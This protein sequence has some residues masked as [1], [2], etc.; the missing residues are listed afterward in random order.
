[1]DDWTLLFWLAD[2][3]NVFPSGHKQTLSLLTLV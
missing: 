1:M 2:C 3:E